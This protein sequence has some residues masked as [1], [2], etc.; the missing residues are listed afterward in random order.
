MK[1]QVK[2][3][4]QLTK[5][6]VL[7]ATANPKKFGYR[8]FKLLKSYGYETYPVNPRETMIDGE[9]CFKS[10]QELPIVPDVVDFVIPP[11]AALEALVECEA[12][13]IKNVWLQPGVNTPEVIEKAQS[14]GLN[15]I[16]DACAMVE[17]S[18]KV[19]LQKKKWVVVDATD[20]ETDD[21]LVLSR[22]LKQRGYSVSLIGVTTGKEEVIT[23]RLFTLLSPIPEVV[24]ITGKPL[25]VTRVLQ[26]CKL[27]GYDSVWLQSG[28]ESEE[29]IDLAISL[30]LIIVH[31]ASVLEELEESGD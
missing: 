25:L 11:A 19:M 28:S 17:S 3:M 10:L 8:I 15:V 26:A 23:D 29:I 31:H 24:A 2:E 16:F 13:G 4:L 21:A 27:A 1:R 12:L 20:G 7:G 9:P 18:K 14:L 22:H 5:W 30:N 6:A